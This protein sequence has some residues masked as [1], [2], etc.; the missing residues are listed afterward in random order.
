[1]RGGE[2]S[3]IWLGESV[4]GCDGMCLAVGGGSLWLAAGGGERGVAVCC[5]AEA[6]CG[7]GG[8]GMVSG[9]CVCALMGMLMGTGSPV[10]VEL[11][12][13]IELPKGTGGL[14]LEGAGGLV[15]GWRG[16]AMVKEKGYADA[17]VCEGSIANCVVACV[18]CVGSI[19]LGGACVGFIRWSLLA[20]PMASCSC[21]I[22]SS[23]LA[24]PPRAEKREEDE[25]GE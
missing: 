1:M 14:V 25:G 6:S 10:D 23:L 8:L 11:L 7:G 3:Y 17:G 2:R 19:G 5:L 4:G 15:A 16:L 18:G 9:G 20:A 22:S 21:S 24:A 13:G 12:E